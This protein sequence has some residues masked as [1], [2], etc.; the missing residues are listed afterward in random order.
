[1]IDTA[2]IPT[3]VKSL[4]PSQVRDLLFIDAMVTRS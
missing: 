4:F 1:M 2:Q 3:R